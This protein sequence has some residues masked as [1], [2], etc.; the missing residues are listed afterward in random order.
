MKYRKL[1]GKIKEV[2]GTIEAFA[3]AMGMKLPRISQRLNGAVS[4]KMNE[5]AKACE[6]LHIPLTEVYLY[7]FDQKV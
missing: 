6:L 2:Y 7:F 3:D 5:I 4:W 1:R